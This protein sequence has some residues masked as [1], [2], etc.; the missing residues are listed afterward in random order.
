MRVYQFRHFGNHLRIAG[1][2]VGGTS[3]PVKGG[4][5]PSAAP[6]GENRAMPP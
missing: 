4:M 3:L 2:S 5:C 6:W 1:E